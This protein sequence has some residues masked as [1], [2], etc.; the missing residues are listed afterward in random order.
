MSETK[1]DLAT[2]AKLAKALDFICGPQH[3]CVL[4]LKAAAASG[5]ERDVKKA[6]TQFLKLKPNERNAAMSMIAE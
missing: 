4:A 6:R 2:M 3:A 5:D 1:I